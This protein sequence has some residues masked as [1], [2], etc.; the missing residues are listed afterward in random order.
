MQQPVELEEASASLQNFY[1]AADASLAEPRPRTLKHGDT[2]ALF[3]E[4][5][6][7]APAE[8]KS[9]GLYH[10][11]T[12]FLSLLRFSIERRAPLLLSST[13]RSNNAVL[14]VDL[15]NPDFT[16]DGLVELAKDTV[17]I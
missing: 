9:Q 4:T 15:T 14:D 11:D 12:R 1:I 13:V 3:G 2:F 5:G 17:H 7:I 6:D 8:S 16:R 10:E